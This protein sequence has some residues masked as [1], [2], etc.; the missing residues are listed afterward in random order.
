MGVLATFAVGYSYGITRANYLDSYTYFMFDA[1]VMGLY[2]AQLFRPQPRSERVRIRPL[3]VWVLILVCWPVLL[4]I[5]PFQ[6]PLIRLVG[7]RGSIFFLPFLL[8][9]AR[10]KTG[11]LH[12]L[13]VGIA[14]LNLCAAA[15]AGVEFFIGIERFFPRNVATDILYRSN[16]VLNTGYRIPSSF[17][18]AAAYAGTM[19]M[20]MPFLIGA[21]EQTRRSWQRLLISAA[22]LASAL[23][24]FMGASR[25]AAIVL[26]LIVVVM[27][28]RT[29]MSGS[30]LGYRTGWI[31]LMACVGWGVWSDQRLQRFTTLSDT[32]YVT[33]RVGN[34]VNMTF[35]DSISTYPIGNGLGGGGTS[36]PYFLQNRLEKPAVLEN[37]YARIALEQGIPGLCLWGAFIIWIF[38]R[39]LN[40]GAKAWQLARRLSWIGC[41]AYFALGMVGT[42]LLTSIPGTC[43]LL[44]SLGWIAVPLS[45]PQRRQAIVKLVP[46]TLLAAHSGTFHSYVQPHMAERTGRTAI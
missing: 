20:T 43:L 8:F 26:F 40:A 17:P 6:D 33:R 18:S 14:V 31:V 3:Q 21:W 29:L 23:G 28:I 34:S 11:D 44:L 46:T 41:A 10:L 16:D 19:V 37:E 5:L 15:L 2:G 22:L 7:L 12:K 32:D 24:V 30:R 4:L 42:G 36:V 1:A 25:S 39:P 9:G 38:T 13:A 27:T 35:F 45:I